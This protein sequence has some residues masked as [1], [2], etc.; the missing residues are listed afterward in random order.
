MSQYGYRRNSFLDEPAHVKPRSTPNGRGPRKPAQKKQ[1]LPV[2]LAIAIDVVLAAVL[3]LVFYLSNY[4]FQ[5]ETGPIGSYATPSWMTSVTPGASPSGSSSALAE[6]SGESTSSTAVIDPND[7][8][9]KFADKFTDGEV[10]KTDTSYRSANISVTIEKVQNDTLTYFV[11][12][13]YIAE[14]KYLR[15]AFAQDAD[16]MGHKALTTTIAQENDAIIAINGD[17]CLNN[18]S[19]GVVLRNG[20][21]YKKNKPSA[22]QFVLYYDGSMESIA[23]GEFDYD[24]VVAQGAYQIWSWGPMLLD[25]G[26]MM[27]D[28]N[29]PDSFGAP[30]PRT[31][32][33]YYEPGPLLLCGRGG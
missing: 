15:T 25:S 12:D 8:R 31:A 1:G 11:A 14:L 13:I 29:M 27:T 22:D 2:G 21:P 6:T 20:Q 7:W 5:G 19:T 3:L 16:T 9:A 18:W 30:N 26:Q 28:F 17:F 10:E 4:V 32:I 24:A 33:G 23:P